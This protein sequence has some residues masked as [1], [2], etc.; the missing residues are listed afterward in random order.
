MTDLKFTDILIDQLPWHLQVTQFLYVPLFLM[1]F[2]R[3]AIT[4]L[5]VCAH[6]HAH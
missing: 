4:V 6:D 5:V 2:N 3:Y 1:P